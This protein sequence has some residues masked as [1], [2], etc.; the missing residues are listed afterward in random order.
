MHR[1]SSTAVIRDATNC[2]DVLRRVEDEADVALQVITG[3]EEARF[4]YGAARRWFGWSRGPMVVIDIGGG[5]LEIAS[6]RNLLPSFAASFP[7][8]A[9]RLT[10]DWLPDGRPTNGQLRAL[11]RHVLHEMR[12]AVARLRWEGSAAFAVGTSKTFKQL[13]LVAGAPRAGLGPFVPRHLSYDDVKDWEQRL[14]AMKPKA[15]AQQR[16][17]S[18]RRAKQIVAGATTARTVMRALNMDGVSICPWGLREGVIL[19]RLDASQPA[20]AAKNQ[21]KLV[22]AARQAGA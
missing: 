10:R 18:R 9:G 3:E 12:D 5:S 16:G 13:A 17:I 7:L 21:A 4:I 6:G 19:G 11:R 22:L 15:R 20:V 1:S 2:A 8:G 14:A